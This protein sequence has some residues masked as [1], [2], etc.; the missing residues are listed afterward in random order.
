MTVNANTKVQHVIQIKNGIIK[1]VNVKVKATINVKKIIDGYLVRYSVTKC[2]ETVIVIDNISPKKKYIIE[3]NVT[4]T[5]CT[6]TV[7]III[8]KKSEIAIF[9]MQFY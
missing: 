1:Y 5:A 2:D 8:G 4:S 9:Y 6:T 3:T 7:L